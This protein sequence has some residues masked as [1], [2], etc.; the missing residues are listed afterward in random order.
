MIRSTFQ[1]IPGVGEGTEKRLW[2]AGCTDW[3]H[4]LGCGYGLSPEKHRRVKA[5]ILESKCRLEAMDHRY[6]RDLLGTGLSW[7]AYDFFRDHACFLDIETTGLAPG[8][9]HVTVVCVHAPGLTK[10]Y[11]AGVNL[12]ELGRDLRSFN[13]VVTFNGARFDL[14]FLSAD[15]GLSFDQI[16]LDL[17]YPL[18]K[19]GL[20]GGL[21]NIERH[22]GVARYTE[23]V[24]GF[25]AVRLWH[26]FRHDKQIEV[27]GRRVKGKDALDLLVEYNREDTVNMEALTEYAVAELKKRCFP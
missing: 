6:F 1:H 21:K 2:S 23:G 27:A 16:H 17:V 18:R 4:I 9:S 26:A 22:L 24:N 15:M 11:V 13:Y 8:R 19:L 25:D 20:R 7:R 12:E 10:S 3:D 5:G 14:P